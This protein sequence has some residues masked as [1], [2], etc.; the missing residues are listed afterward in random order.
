[1]QKATYNKEMPRLRP[2]ASKLRKK[3]SLCGD[4]QVEVID[5][6]PKETESPSDGDEFKV[7]E[8]ADK[9]AGPECLIEANVGDKKL[10][11]KVDTGSQVNLL[12]P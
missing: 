8:V 3:K 12:P 5:G 1:M 6:V 9:K 11:L 7:L 4:L 2:T 10:K